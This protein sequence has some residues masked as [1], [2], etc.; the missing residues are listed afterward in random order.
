M[1]I[2]PFDEDAK[3]GIGKRSLSTHGATYRIASSR[4]IMFKEMHGCDD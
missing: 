3:C 4:Q 2:N 1:G